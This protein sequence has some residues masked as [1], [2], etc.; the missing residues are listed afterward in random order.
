MSNQ[1]NNKRG[2]GAGLGS[3]LAL[4]ALVLSSSAFAAGLTDSM[5]MIAV[6]D[7]ETGQLRG[8]TPAE[9]QLMQAQQ[10]SVRVGAAGLITGTVSP[11][12]TI[13]KFGAKKLEMTE[14]T[15][16][17]SVVTRK[18]DGSL[19]MQCVTGADAANK[20]INNKSTTATSSEHKH[21]K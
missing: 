13:N 1:Q 9:A 7:A 4:G 2:L 14:D 10:N 12:M 3:I 5:G 21:D 15:L 6:R 11:Q 17:Y 16:V 19:D 8:A 18:A 20:F